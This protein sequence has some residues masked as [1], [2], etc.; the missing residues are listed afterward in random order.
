MSTPTQQ[1]SESQASHLPELLADYDGAVAAVGGGDLEA[2]LLSQWCPPPAVAAC[3]GAEGDDGQPLAS[4][5]EEWSAD[6]ECQAYARCDA[7][8]GG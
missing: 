2:R 3:G 8:S 5:S 4:E 7:D 6:A 1:I